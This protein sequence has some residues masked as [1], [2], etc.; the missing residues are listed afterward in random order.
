MI[1]SKSHN[2]SENCIGCV[3][4]IE[5]SAFATTQQVETLA[6]Y[7]NL[8]GQVNSLVATVSLEFER[9]FI[10]NSTIW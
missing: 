4:E 1:A 3:G 10:K 5:A 2:L 6:F 9:F 7:A 8:K